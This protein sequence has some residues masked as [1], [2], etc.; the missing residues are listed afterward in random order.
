MDKVKLSSSEVKSKQL[1]WNKREEVNGIS[2]SINVKQVE[3]GFVVNISTYG[4]DTTKKDSE[5]KDDYKTYISKTNP[6]EVKEEKPSLREEI[7]KALQN[8]KL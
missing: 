4:R 8:I 5:Y 6:L 7:N 2:T 1:E 3:N